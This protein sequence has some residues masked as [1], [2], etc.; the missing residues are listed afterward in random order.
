MAQYI[1][2]DWKRLYDRLPFAPPRD[3]DKREKDMTVIDRISARRDRTPEET[4]IT[5]LE[6]WRNFNRHGDI[7]QLIKGLRKLNKVELAEKVETKYTVEDV[8]S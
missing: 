8:Y 6:K 1:G 2:R 4:A 3:P 5:C 7:A